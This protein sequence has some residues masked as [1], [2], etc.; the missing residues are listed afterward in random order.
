MRLKAATGAGF[1]GRAHE[2]H[3]PIELQEREV[4]VQVMVRRRGVENEIEAAG[5]LPHLVR[6]LGRD[7]LVRTEALGI[8]RLVGRRREENGVRAERV[9]KFQ[10]H[11]SE[12]AQTHD[13]DLLPFP[14]LPVAQRRVRRDARAQKRRHARG[15]E[16]PRHAQH[17]ALVD[18]DAVG[19]AAGG[20]TA[21]DLVGRV[22]RVRRK[23]ETVLFFAGLAARAFAARSHHATDGGQVALLELLHGAADLH[24][25]THDLVPGHAR[26]HRRH[27]AFPLVSRLMQIRVADAAVKDLDLDILNAR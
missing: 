11:V 15:I 26:V 13:A 16:R 12:S 22:V 6:V 19:V 18:D 17:E 20:H 23:I 7:H 24:D 25:A 1:F 5:V 10:A 9:R 27:H 14:D 8:R 4:R 21:G 2:R 3:R